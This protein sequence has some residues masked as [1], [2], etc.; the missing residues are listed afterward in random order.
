MSHTVCRITGKARYRFWQQW[1]TVNVCHQVWKIEF[2]LS[3]SAD[4]FFAG[5]GISQFQQRTFHRKH[6]T[7][8]EFNV[9]H[10]AKRVTICEQSTFMFTLM[11]R[12]IHS[13]HWGCAWI[14]NYDTSIVNPGAGGFSVDICGCAWIVNHCQSPRIHDSQLSCVPRATYLAFIKIPSLM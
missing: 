12:M 8:E 9:G 13:W 4:N 1:P 3:F 5:R 7:F 2:H 14:V 11:G 6:H 10:R